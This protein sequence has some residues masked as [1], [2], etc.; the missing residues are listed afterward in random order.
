MEKSGVFGFLRKNYWVFLLILIFLTALYLR[1][2]PGTKL[3]YPRLMAIDPYFFFRMGEHLIEHGE[4]PK[5]DYLAQWGTTPG[6]PDRT[7]N[8][9]I[10]ILA[11]PAMYF[12]LHPILGVSWYW[13]GVWIPAFFGAL[14]VL[15]MYF[16]GKELF[17]KRVGLLSAAFLA[18]VPGVLYRSSA[19]FIEK[20]PLAGIFM[21]LALWSFVKSFK[22]KKIERGVSI[23][24]VLIHPLSILHKTSLHEEKI[25]NMKTIIYGFL[26]G[27]FFS[28][29]AGASGLVQIPLIVVGTF[30]GLSLLLNRYSRTF[31]YAYI[32][33][34]ISYLFVSRF[35]PSPPSLTSIG[36]MVNF[37][38]FFLFLIRFGIERFNLVKKEYLPYTIPVLF[39]VFIF[40]FLITSYV[41]VDV[42]VWLSGILVRIS[43]PISV[44]VIGSTVAE[45]QTAGAFLINSVSTYGTRNAIGYFKLPGFFIYLSLIYFSF[46][47]VF[48]MAYEFLF[49]RRLLEFILSIVFFLLCMQFAIGAMR[50]GFV[51]SFP[52][53]IVAAYCIVRGGEYVIRKSRDL[54]GNLPNYVKI[55]VGV[56]IGLVVITNFMSGW[57]MANSIGSSLDNSWYEA[58]VWLRD[59]TPEDSV[60]LEWWDYGWWFHYI[61]K[62]RTLVDGGFHPRN[63]T[64]DIAKFFTEPL[65]DRSLNFLKHYNITYVMVSPDLISKFGA[66]SKIANWGEKIDT[67][68]V[69]RLTN[70]YQEGDKT[71]LEYSLGGREKIL[72]A[73]SV[74]SQGNLTTMGNVTALIKTARGQAYIR[75]VGISNQ[76]IR[77]DKPNTVPGMV[78]IAGDAVIYI[79]EA[80]E[81]CMFV[82]LYLFN[83]FGL[84][85]LFEKQY[86]KLGMKIYKVI[87]ENF[88]E[89]IT[90]EY[91]NAAYLEG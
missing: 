62:R 73:F 42:G 21:M 33:M 84:E 60:V 69:F 44:D 18:F 26:S 24:Y 10:T 74:V 3:T 79:P 82:R 76:I 4:I 78:Y 8:F 81:E 29:M 34:F 55:L 45:S 65:S 51:F 90:G 1:G 31:M 32:S 12:I 48:L 20:E 66:M 11:Y 67:L 53:S 28:L 14:Q 37:V 77:N 85:T 2:I 86:D 75:D 38:P 30:V 68:P 39:V 83:G 87:Y 61:A 25:K 5:H 54:K 23:S 88:P 89:N 41:V 47:G 17:N 80:V 6:G 52:A 71:L 15:F 43:N 58:L 40:A 22:E 16:L 13:V 64:Q 9:M 59:E 72:V 57:V 49:K 36:V 56:F 46:I 7:R 50:F 35:L 91:V 70:R 63:P 27:F 19:G